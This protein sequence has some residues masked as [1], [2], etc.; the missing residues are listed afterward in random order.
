MKVLETAQQNCSILG[1]D[2]SEKPTQRRPLNARNG[3]ILVALIMGTSL[4]FGYRIRFAIHNTVLHVASY[5]VYNINRS[6]SLY[7]SKSNDQGILKAV[8]RTN[9]HEVQFTKQLC[10]FIQLHSIAKQLS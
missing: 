4:S 1:I 8:S 10:D 5:C 9:E 2:L 7:V 6:R 3:F